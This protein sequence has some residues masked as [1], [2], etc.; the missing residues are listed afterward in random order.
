MDKIEFVKKPLPFE[1]NVTCLAAIKEE[2]KAL[3]NTVIGGL[4]LTSD[5]ASPDTATTPKTTVLHE[6]GQNDENKS[7]ESDGELSDEEEDRKE[8]EDN[9]RATFRTILSDGANFILSDQ[10]PM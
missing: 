5:T 6:Y 8:E 10:I 9:A 3:Q 7:A 2:T 1:A 4:Q